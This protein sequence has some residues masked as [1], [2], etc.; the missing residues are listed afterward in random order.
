MSFVELY[1]SDFYDLF[2]YSTAQRAPSQLRILD[3]RG[4]DG[5]VH[6]VISNVV[7]LPVTSAADVM[8]YE[9]LLMCVSRSPSPSF[10][11]SSHPLFPLPFS[12]F[13]DTHA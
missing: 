6:V 5:A 11:L 7:T 9:E 1:N 4:Q 3:Q 8:G 13:L 10:S 12:L 2:D